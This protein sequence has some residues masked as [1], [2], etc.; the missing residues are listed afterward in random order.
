M[1]CGNQ[2]P[3]LRHRTSPQPYSAFS[4]IYYSQLKAVKCLWS[5]GIHFRLLREGQLPL[6]RST[7]AQ[8]GADT[9]AA[10]T[11]LFPVDSAHKNPVRLT[12]LE[13]S[14]LPSSQCQAGQGVI[15]CVWGEV[16]TPCTMDAWSRWDSC[17]F[18]SSWSRPLPHWITAE[19][20]PLS[21]WRR[22]QLEGDTLAAGSSLVTQAA[23]RR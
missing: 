15:P 5:E 3:G 12:A 6:H 14:S 10:I 19:P 2:V 11:W 13:K 7:V 23:P 16:H 4:D 9:W 22:V 21:P 17:H 1:C 20:V 18:G 8:P